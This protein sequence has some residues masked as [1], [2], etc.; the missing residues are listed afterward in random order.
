MSPPPDA[1]APLPETA[2]LPPEAEPRPRRLSEELRD[3]LRDA[4]GHDV[5]LGEL[6]QRL[7]G[8]GFAL[9]ILLLSVPFCFPIAIPG[10]SIPFG[11]VIMLLGIR[12]ALGRKPDLPGF[13]LAK[14]IRYGNLE[15][16]VTLGI[17]LCTKIEKV[18]RPRMH[19]FRRSSLA[20]NLIGI[21]LA[22]AGL[23]LLMPIPG[24]FPLT[25]TIPAISA[26]LLTVGLIERDGI[27]VLAGYVTNVAGWIYFTFIFAAAGKG[28]EWLYERML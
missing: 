20:V 23:Q 26:V 22:S 24:V 28:I 2:P 21:G 1:L 9:F 12:I 15:R 16:I 6:E 13:I 19:F 14:K 17:K 3:V 11:I 25:N 7:Q 18:A 4:M 10:L 8:R 5:T 27:F